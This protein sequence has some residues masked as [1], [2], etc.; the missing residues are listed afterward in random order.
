MNLTR[1]ARITSAATVAGVAAV[2]SYSHMRVLASEHGQG[3]LLANLLPVSV[4][5]MLV[6]ASVVMADD[7][8]A[9][10][11]PRVSAKVSFVTGVAASI[12]ANVLAAPDDLISRVI[13]AWPALALLLVVEMLAGGRSTVQDRT[14]VEGV[15]TADAL[16]R[17]DKTP[18]TSN[19][20]RPSAASKVHA[21]RQAQPDAALADIAAT[22]G[23]STRTAR[24]HLNGGRPAEKH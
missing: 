21:A 18:P 15:Q 12:L 14:P 19:G 1:I 4:D 2:A 6:V 8:A 20:G 7:R 16:D 9:G 5:G 24:R 13:S 3:E 10:R 23:V 11:A 17:A 22:A